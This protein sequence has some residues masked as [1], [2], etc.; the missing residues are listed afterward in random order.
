MYHFK[1]SIHVVKGIGPTLANDLETKNISSVL[2]IL[3]RLPFRYEDRSQFGTIDQLQKDV[4]ITFQA[5]VMQ[6]STSYRGRKVMTKATLQD[7]TGRINAFWF[8]NRFIGSQLKKGSEWFFSGKLSDR[9]VLVQP[10]VEKI[11][12]ET[13]NTGRLVPMYSEI[14]PHLKVGSF[15]R[16][17]KEIIDRLEDDSQDKLLPNNLMPLAKALKVLHFPEDADQVPLARER[18]ALE[19]LLSLI[20]HSHQIKEAWKNTHSALPME[21]PEKSNDYHK[22]LANKLPFAL[23][24]AQERSVQEVLGDLQNDLPMNRLLIGDV[25]SGKTVVV[26]IGCFVAVVLNKKNAVIV[27]PTQILA[28]QHIETIKKLFPTMP[29]A[30]LTTKEAKK[31]EVR[32]TPTLYIGT[33]AVLNQLEKIDPVLVAYDEQHRFGVKQRSLPTMSHGTP[34]TLTLSATPIPR[35][36]MLTLFSHMTLSII[37]E[38]PK[39]RLPTKTWLVGDQKKISSLQWIG[40]TLEKTKGQALIVCPFI[41]PSVQETLSNVAAAKDLFVTIKDFYQKSNPK[42]RVG[43]LHGKLSAKEKQLAIDGVFAKKI[44][45][46]V[47]T[48]VVEVGVDLPQA[49]IIMI[50]AAE[51]FGLASLHQ[52]RGRVGRA[53]QESYCLL[54]SNSKTSETI[55]RLQLFTQENN[56]LKLAERDLQNRGAGDLFGFQ[57][58]GLDTLRFASWTNLELIQAA[59]TSYQLIKNTNWQPIFSFQAN[60]D[61]PAPN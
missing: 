23:T 9:N 30:L 28:Q 50:E 44:D 18:L 41:E 36:L 22:W 4:V 51:R 52:L 20:F 59:H 27:A 31:F 56:G 49:N 57:Q 10:V 26:G 16:I 7:T 38:M 37:D 14:G 35:S 19:E 34:H 45:V 61:L 43:L 1:E 25:G 3:L 48:P 11:Q 21:L 5:H 24:A 58:H 32:T 12:T 39:G 2:D 46:L 47:T 53:G 15:R 55:D 13:I 40:E 8:N 42:L 17:V 33:H 29:V 54:F 60:S 6:I